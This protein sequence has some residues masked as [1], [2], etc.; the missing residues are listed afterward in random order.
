MWLE[1][2]KCLIDS[3][4]G[5][6]IVRRFADNS[7]EENYYRDGKLHREDG[8]AYIR[9]FASG[10]VEEAYY[11]D[12]KRHREDGPAY[13]WDGADGWTVEIHYR[14]GEFVKEERLAP[15]SA[16]CGVTVQRPAPKLQSGPGAPGPG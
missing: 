1:V 7:T 6:A 5:P 14:D 2:R 15:L 3:P 9:R 13:V 4:D 8:P 10:T 12:D 11:R 16:I